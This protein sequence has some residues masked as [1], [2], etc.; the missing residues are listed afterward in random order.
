MLFLFLQILFVILA[1]L[2]GSIPFG[3]VISKSIKGIDIRTQGSKNVGTTNVLRVVGLKCALLVLVFDMLK[4]SI[5]VIISSILINKNVI[6]NSNSLIII[7]TIFYGLAGFLGHT[8]SVYLKFKGG[9]GV[10]TA[11]GVI[12]FYKPLLFCIALIVFSVVLIISK[13]V[14]LSSI[15]STFACFIISIFINIPS[16]DYWM[17]LTLFIFFS[18]ILF[19]HR[20]NIKRI[21]N[22]QESSINFKSFKN[23]DEPTFIVK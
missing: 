13:Y 16:F 5:F 19:L 18:L 7:P 6:N 9:K 21:I 8:F 14:S 23:K 15:I 17:I 4:G 10:A 1:Y 3:I 2:I 22:K 12:L 20:S 11:A